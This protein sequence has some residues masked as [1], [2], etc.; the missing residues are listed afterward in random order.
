MSRVS[1]EVARALTNDLE[2]KYTK[3]SFVTEIVAVAKRLQRDQ[4][5]RRSL[6][7]RLKQTDARI[8]TLKRELKALSSALQKG[9]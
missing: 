8:K 9:D 5:H 1:Q 6:R 4:A 2:P 3:P 7:M